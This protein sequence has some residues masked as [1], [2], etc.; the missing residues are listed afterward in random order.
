MALDYFEKKAGEEE[1]CEGMVAWAQPSGKLR[2]SAAQGTA[3]DLALAA[4]KHPHP[5]LTPAAHADVAATPR[6]WRCSRQ[7]SA[8]PDP[9]EPAEQLWQ[10]QTRLGPGT[11]AASHPQPS[12]QGW[13]AESNWAEI[14]HFPLVTGM[15]SGALPL[16]CQPIHSRCTSQIPTPS[17]SSQLRGGTHSTSPGNILAPCWHPPFQAAGFMPKRVHTSPT[18]SNPSHPGKCLA[19]SSAQPLLQVIKQCWGQDKLPAGLHTCCKSNKRKREQQEPE[20]AGAFPRGKWPAAPFRRLAGYCPAW[21]QEKP[22]LP[23]PGGLPQHSSSKGALCTSTALVSPPLSW[24]QA[25]RHLPP[26]MALQ[27]MSAAAS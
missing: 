11:A 15:D 16:L 26:P 10:G 17:G 21:G 18:S 24:G 14:K 8:R 9:V 25:A 1:C 12:A 19:S 20:P 23:R 6:P 13:G 3:Q 27:P 4:Q 7:P 2:L 22:P 5:P